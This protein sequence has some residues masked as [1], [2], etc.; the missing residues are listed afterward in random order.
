MTG[1][2]IGE[3]TRNRK[4][5]LAALDILSGKDN[6]LEIAFKYGYETYES[7]NKAFVR[8][9]EITPTGLRRD[10]SNLSCSCL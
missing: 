5:Y 10:P 4:L 3:Y 8:F 7:F 2:S 9:H 1:Y 6:L